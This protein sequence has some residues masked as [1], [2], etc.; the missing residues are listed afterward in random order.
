MEYDIEN[1]ADLL[2]PLS[3]ESSSQFEGQPYVPE[4][5]R[6]EGYRILLDKKVNLTPVSLITMPKQSKNGAKR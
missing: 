1:R 5:L 2:T 6:I 4:K 3:E